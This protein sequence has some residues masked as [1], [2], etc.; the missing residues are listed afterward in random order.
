MLLSEDSEVKRDG[1]GKDDVI[2][3]NR[4]DCLIQAL[5]GVLDFGDLNL[6]IPKEATT[7]KRILLKPVWDQVL[8]HL[9]AA[10]LIPEQ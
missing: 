4:C 5:Q 6:N 7:A 10:G 8:Q 2:F 1:T 3:M 9:T